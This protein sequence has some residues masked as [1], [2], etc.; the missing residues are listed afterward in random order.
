MPRAARNAVAR[1]DDARPLHLARRD[2]VAQR[3]RRPVAVAEVADGGEARAQRLHAVRLGIEGLRGGAE[4]DLFEL[5]GDAARVAR[6]MDVTVDQ[7]GEDIFVLEVNQRRVGFGGL[8]AVGNAN[9]LATF[10][11]DRRCTARGLAGFG[12][13]LAGVDDAARRRLRSERRGERRADQRERKNM[14]RLHS[15]IPCFDIWGVLKP[16]RSPS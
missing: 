12:E 13:Q 5:A 2:R 7:A 9:D 15:G 10:D 3:Q 1:I 4:R 14:N 11:D 8:I 16:I 6:Q